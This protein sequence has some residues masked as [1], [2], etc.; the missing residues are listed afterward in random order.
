MC[1]NTFFFRSIYQKIREYEVLDR[2][3]TV[4]ALRAGEDRA[5]LLGLSMVFLSVMM[6]FIL[7]ITVLR[8][9]SD[10][11]YLHH[12][13]LKAVGD[14]K[15]M[16][17]LLFLC[18]WLNCDY[19]FKICVHLC[20]TDY[21]LRLQSTCSVHWRKKKVLS[22]CSVWTDEASCTVVNSTIMWDVNCSYSCGSECWKSSRYPCLQVYISL[23]SSGKVMRLFH[24]EETQDSNP[25]VLHHQH[26]RCYTCSLAER[27]FL[28]V[29]GPSINFFW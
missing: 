18:V 17:L 6:Y 13:H 12:D 19:W 7:G 8:S 2:R 9:H 1:L 25:E 4:T 11:F 20:P 28:H 3:K 22:L 10:R 21:P 15:C 29:E 24:N 16:L 5:I 27:F 14:Q 23:N 26:W